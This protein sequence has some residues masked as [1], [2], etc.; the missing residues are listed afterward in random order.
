MPAEIET[1]TAI[2]DQGTGLRLSIQ[3]RGDRYSHR[4]S[5]VHPG[6]E[7]TWL[8]SLDEI[9]GFSPDWPPS[10]PIQQYSIEPRARERVALCVGMAGR[11]HWSS[12]M[13]ADS[14]IRTLTLDVACRIRDIP[15]WLGNQYACHLTD[16]V[17]VADSGESLTW[18]LSAHHP[19][20]A[21]LSTDDTCATDDTC[22]LATIGRQLQLRLVSRGNR[23]QCSYQ[24][25]SR[26]SVISADL[27]GLTVPTTV[28]WIMQLSLE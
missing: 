16:P 1:V 28:R 21:P 2:D 24:S 15:A 18:Q 19:I 12:S 20:I 9:P 26:R 11:S 6:E 7:F 4:V 5:V 27:T 22:D 3:R 25:D 13:E 10:P 8:E 23:V 17:I 14:R